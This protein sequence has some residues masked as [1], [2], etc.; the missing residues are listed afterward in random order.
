MR[1]ERT[2]DEAL[3]EIDRWSAKLVAKIQ[4]LSPAETVAYFEEAGKRHKARI[5]KR[6]KSRKTRAK[7]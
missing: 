6:R 5:K 1:R 7:T 4:H 2:F 3:N